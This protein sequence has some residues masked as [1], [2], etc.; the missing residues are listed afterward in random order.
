MDNDESKDEFKRSDNF[1]IEEQAIGFMLDITNFLKKEH[2]KK[3]YISDQ[4]DFDITKES[5]KNLFECFV[6]SKQLFIKK[7]ILTKSMKMQAND[8]FDLLNIVYV[9]KEQTL[10]DKGKKVENYIKR[11]SNG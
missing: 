9:D 1:Q 2:D 7:L 5:I 6:Y 4:N 11:I 8:F 3:L 10:L